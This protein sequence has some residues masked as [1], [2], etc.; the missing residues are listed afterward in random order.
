MI[1]WQ[2]NSIGGYY[3]FEGTD[4]LNPPLFAHSRTQTIDGRSYKLVDDGEHIHVVGWQSGR[5]L[6]WVTN[7]LLE[8]LSNA[9][10]LAIAE[11]SPAGPPLGCYGIAM[12]IAVRGGGRRA[13][14]V[15]SG[16]DERVRVGVLSAGTVRI[17]QRSKSF[18]AASASRCRGFIASCLTL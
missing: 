15:E 13:C 10:M 2:Q 11:I 18:N 16:V 14:L 7:T 8:E 12:A 17:D 6:Y 5:V 4:W 1:V 9:Q 3:D